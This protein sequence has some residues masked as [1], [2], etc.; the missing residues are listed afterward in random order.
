[1][2]KKDILDKDKGESKSIININNIMSDPCWTQIN[3]MHM[4]NVFKQSKAKVY[5]QFILYRLDGS[6]CAA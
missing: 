5:F 1:M 3:Q 2:K 4:K 6:R